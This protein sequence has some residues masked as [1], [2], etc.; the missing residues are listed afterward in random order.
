MTERKGNVDVENGIFFAI[1]GLITVALSTSYN[2]GTTARMGPGFFPIVLSGVLVVLGIA[3]L[4]AGLGNPKPVAPDA[5]VL[6]SLV[7]ICAS[8]VLF[9]LV[10]MRAGLLVTVPVTAIVASF[11]QHELKWKQTG[12]I[13][14]ALTAFTW[15][16]FTVGLDLRFPL[17]PRGF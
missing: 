2:F 12:I 4:I 11:A 13:A 14:V 5:F 8:I 10:L 1:V 7:I 15:L 6:K 3:I 9:G 17:L 16:V